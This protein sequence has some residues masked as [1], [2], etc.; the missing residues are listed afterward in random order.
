MRVDGHQ[1]YWSLERQDYCWLGPDR[2]LL[3]RNYLPHDLEP[4]LSQNG[5]ERTIVVQSTPTLAETE[6]LLLMSERITSIAGV[7]GWI[8]PAASTALKD[9]D[10]FAEHDKFCGIRMMAQAEEDPNWLDRSDFSKTL[11]RLIAL[12]KC[13]DVLVREDQLGALERLIARHPNLPVVINHAAK[14]TISGKTFHPWSVT[15]RRLARYPNVYCKLSGLTAGANA[16]VTADDL[17]PFVQEIVDSFGPKRTIWGSD[18]P[19]LNETSNYGAWAALT[20][21]LLAS[22]NPVDR[23]QIMGECARTVYQLLP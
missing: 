12:D 5:V 15:L 3:N 6:F 21:E 10:R 23:G 22:L 16:Q 4:I 19:V 8:D 14:P 17:A 13:L 11:D 1:H 18:W 20:D 2:S 7:V 9:L